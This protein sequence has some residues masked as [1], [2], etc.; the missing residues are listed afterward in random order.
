MLNT[1]RKI[2]R[3][4]TAQYIPRQP[5][6]TRSTIF[7]GTKYGGWT[8]HPDGLNAESVVYAFGV[9]EDISFDLAMMATYGVQLHAFDPTPRSLAWVR[10]QALPE[11]FHLHEYGLEAYDGEATFYAPENEAYVSHS[12]L[13]RDTTATQVPVKRLDTIMAELGHQRIDLLKMDIEGSEYAVIEKFPTG[14]D[15]RQILV[16]FHPNLLEDGT[17]RTRQA[18]HTLNRHGYQIFHVAPGRWEYAFIK[19]TK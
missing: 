19:E 17:S 6:T 14:V 12:T 4:L 1:L 16:E 2:K 8:I 9:G 11:S 15:V 3:R 5:Q 10:S 13:K 7:H 18:I